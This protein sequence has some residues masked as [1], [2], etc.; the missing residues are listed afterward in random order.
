MSGAT[1]PSKSSVSCS[2]KPLMLAQFSSLFRGLVALSVGERGHG[3]LVKGSLPLPLPPRAALLVTR[4]SR[5]DGAGEKAPLD[6]L[7]Q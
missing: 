1:Y 5:D 4:G 7:L 2:Q 3:S 6:L